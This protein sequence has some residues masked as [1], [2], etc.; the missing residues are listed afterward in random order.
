MEFRLTYDGCLPSAGNNTR[1]KEKQDIRMSLHPQLC[2]LWC[3]HPG[4]KDL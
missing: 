4:L 2:E 1:K 3:T